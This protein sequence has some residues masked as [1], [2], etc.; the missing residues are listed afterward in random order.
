MKLIANIQDTDFKFRWIAD[1]W[2]W[3]LSGSCYFNNNLCEFQFDWSKY[4]PDSDYLDNFYYNIYS[5]N[6]FEKVKWIL[7]QKL[8][9]ICVGYH[10]TSTNYKS[11]HYRKPIWLYKKLFHFYYSIQNFLKNFSE[12]S[13]G[14]L[15]KSLR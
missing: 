15:G 12:S 6:F 7:R 4:K 10:W 3:H 1:H 8:F 13:G 9:E 5:L 11:F 2:D 14:L